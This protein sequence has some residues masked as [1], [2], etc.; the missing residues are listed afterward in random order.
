MQDFDSPNIGACGGW[1]NLSLATSIVMNMK[2]M[3]SV[4]FEVD[5]R[6]DGLRIPLQRMG[7]RNPWPPM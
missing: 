2:E 5:N 7:K 3:S 6:D 4:A 1:F